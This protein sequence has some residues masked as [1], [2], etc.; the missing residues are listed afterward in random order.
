MRIFL[1]EEIGR[2]NILLGLTSDP[3]YRLHIARNGHISPGISA[4]AYASASIDSRQEQLT[5]ASNF[6]TLETLEVWEIL[7]AS[8]TSMPRFCYSSEHYGVLILLIEICM[9]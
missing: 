6:E 5:V 4:W 7:V 3:I 2:A 1:V 8:M 9:G